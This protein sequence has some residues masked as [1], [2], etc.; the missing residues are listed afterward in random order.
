MRRKTRIRRK[1]GSKTG[2]GRRE[3]RGK[4]GGGQGWGGGSTLIVNM[5]LSL[6]FSYFSTICLLPD[7]SVPKSSLLNSCTND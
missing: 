3:G 1:R 7:F 2:R 6:L 4:G 5:I